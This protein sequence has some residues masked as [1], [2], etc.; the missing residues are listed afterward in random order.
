MCV[1][2]KYIYSQ[3]V[4]SIYFI[5]ADLRFVCKWGLWNLASPSPA[6]YSQH[7]SVTDEGWAFIVVQLFIW[8]FRRRNLNVNFF[9][10]SLWLNTFLG[11]WRLKVDTND[12]VCMVQWFSAIVLIAWGEQVM[13]IHH[14]TLHRE[15][16]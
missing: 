9:S 5:T 13:Q 4:F 8:F 12:T 1:Y 11:C 3:Y 7:Y 16:L 2:I 6:P 14:L 15:G 10:S